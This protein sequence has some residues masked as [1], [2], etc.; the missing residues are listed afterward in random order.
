MTIGVGWHPPQF[1]HEAARVSKTFFSLVA[2]AR[3]PEQLF[4]SGAT[5]SLVL[6]IDVAAS[7]RNA[8]SHDDRYGQER[9]KDGRS[10]VS[11]PSL[12]A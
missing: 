11:C 5:G 2:M 12:L 1:V 6:R 10:N 8:H 4:A 7:Y 9:Q 3:R